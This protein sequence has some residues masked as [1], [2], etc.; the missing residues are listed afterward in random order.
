MYHLQNPLWKDH[1]WFKKKIK[2]FWFKQKSLE[3]N[4]N[5]TANVLY[6]SKDLPS[7]NASKLKQSK[8]KIQHKNRVLLLFVLTLFLVDL[9]PSAPRSTIWAVFH[10]SALF[11]RTWWNFLAPCCPPSSDEHGAGAQLCCQTPTFN[12]WVCS[13]LASASN[14]VC[15]WEDGRWPGGKKKWKAIN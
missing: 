15:A 6:K 11:F 7:P 1:S 4:W 10:H 14:L 12:A 9:L 5:F 13:R 8:L 3:R 2:S